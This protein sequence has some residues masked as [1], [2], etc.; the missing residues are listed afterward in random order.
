MESVEAHD[1]LYVKQQYLIHLEEIP[2]WLNIEEK[3]WVVVRRAEMIDGYVPV[4]VRGNQR[5][6]RYACFLKEEMIEKKITPKELL[7]HKFLEDIPLNRQEA[8]EI[9]QTFQQL[10][11]L[12]SHYEWGIGGSLAYELVS[13][14]PTVKQTS[15]LD[16]LIYSKEK[17][18]YRQMN[19]LYDISQNVTTKI[20]M[21]IIT[22]FGGC[23][24]TE[25][26]QSKNQVLLKTNS[27][28]V[29]T[30]NPWEKPIQRDRGFF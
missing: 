27:G 16:V 24:L 18:D 29:L 11:K 15:D 6:Q 13:K 8:L 14:R 12:L 30:N 20:D 10:K 2:T 26:C 9:F 3:E 5:N 22:L 7:N 17:L 19:E 21:Q 1:L 28:P 23:S 4:G 25:L